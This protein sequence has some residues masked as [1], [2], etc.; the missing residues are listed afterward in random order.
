MKKAIVIFLSIVLISFSYS[1]NNDV[2]G[3][4]LK[5]EKQNIV[6][7]LEDL[8]NNHAISKK[9]KKHIDDAIEKINESLD[10][11]YWKND[12][13]LNIKEGEKVLNLDKNSINKL[14][15][16]LE[17]KKESP[18]IKN[19]IFI[20][21]LKIAEIDKSLVNNTIT[22]IQEIIMSE[23]GVKKLDKAI[24]NFEEGD[25]L[26]DN[27]DYD[28]AMKKF[29]KSWDLIRQ[30]LKDPNV[31]KMK[32]IE[33]EG[34]GD[35][36]F[37]GVPDVYLKLVDVDKANKPKHVKIKITGECVNGIIHDDASMKIGFSTPES[38]STVFFDEEFTATN[39]WFKKYDPDKKIN[40]AVITTVAEYFS[41]PSS[42]D[43]LIQM[44]SGN[45]FGSFEFTNQPII[46]I[47]EQTGWTGEFSLNGEPGDYFL[48]FFLP[49]TEP[50]NEGD[51]C[52]FVSSFPIPTTI[53]P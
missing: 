4:D 17:D 51:S 8:K 15:S 34:T 28:K 16:I 41:F 24:Q 3:L 6:E 5:Q 22:S 27:S 10:E 30:S 32:M 40:P 20:I 12:S 38:L 31:K 18:I 53:N 1:L 44:N 13:E 14:D 26:L 39:K 43:D 9:S 25:E 37:D 7:S 45:E 33:F 35:F 21:N 23:K 29:L 42:G 2:Y 50:T 36:N 46:E 49:L 19:E 47:G 52:N 11:K 48:R